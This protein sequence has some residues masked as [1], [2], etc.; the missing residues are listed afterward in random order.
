MYRTLAE[1]VPPSPRRPSRRSCGAPRTTCASC[2][3]EAEFERHEIEWTD[4]SPESYARFMLDSFGPLLNARE[5]LA[6]REDE[7]D[8]A[9]TNFLRE[10]EPE[11]RR[12]AAPP[13]SSGE[14]LP[15]S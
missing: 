6:E 10:R 13:T 8:E 3:G 7:L 5:V 14:Y 2:W 1:L 11:R 9:F 12:H 4:E 15:P